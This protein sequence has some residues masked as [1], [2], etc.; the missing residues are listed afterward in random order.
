MKQVPYLLTLALVL[1]GQP[2]VAEDRPVTPRSEVA[3]WK[4]DPDKWK[5]KL[6]MEGAPFSRGQ[7]IV[8]TIMLTNISNST[9][10]LLHSAFPI[11]D[12]YIVVSDAGGHQ[13]KLTAEGEETLGPSPVIGSRRWFKIAPSKS[14]DHK[15]DLA[16]NFDLSTPGKYTV[17][18]GRHET[19]WKKPIPLKLT[20]ESFTVK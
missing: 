3:D 7:E 15:I 18:V 2:V 10:V 19:I 14:D 11:R 8:M 9:E 1:L 17:T 20:S 5:V 6:H 16:K 12:F 4:L 13:A